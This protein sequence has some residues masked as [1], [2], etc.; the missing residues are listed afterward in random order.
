VLRD[1]QV[2]GVVSRSDVLAALARA[3]AMLD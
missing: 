2:V 3:P 1:G